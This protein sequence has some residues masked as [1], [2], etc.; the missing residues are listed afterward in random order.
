MK[1]LKNQGIGHSLPFVNLRHPSLS[2]PVR[3]L[4]YNTEILRKNKNI[5]EKKAPPIPDGENR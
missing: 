1:D 4:L 5:I 2:F 3:T